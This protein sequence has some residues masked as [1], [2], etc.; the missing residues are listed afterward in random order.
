[1][2]KTSLRGYKFNYFLQF[3]FS[4][5]FFS[6]FQFC[7]AIFL[8]FKNGSFVSYLYNYLIQFNRQSLNFR[9]CV[10]AVAGGWG[11][12]GFQA[13]YGGGPP[14]VY[15]SLGGGVTQVPRRG[16]AWCRGCLRGMGGGRDLQFRHRHSP[17]RL[18]DQWP[19][20]RAPPRIAQTQVRIC[21]VNG[22][23]LFT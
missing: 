4:F 3:S 15:S 20:A 14:T 13:P 11:P 17:G 6:V 22:D 7:C 16:R 12:G 5:P 18:V 9:F 2:K 23:L 21:E 10:S 19:D 8:I 1:M